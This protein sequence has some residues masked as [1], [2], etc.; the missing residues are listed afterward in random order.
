MGFTFV[1]MII[2]GGLLGW[3]LVWALGTYDVVWLEREKTFI[4]GGVVF[5]IVIGMVDFIRTAKRAIR[6]MQ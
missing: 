4:V 5:G 1:S 6:D 3:M 2:A